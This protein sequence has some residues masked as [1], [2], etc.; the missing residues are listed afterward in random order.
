MPLQEDA[1]STPASEAAGIGDAASET[2][3]SSPEPLRAAQGRG[4]PPPVPT[5]QCL[6]PR[7]AHG[8]PYLPGCST[9]L[10]L[11]SNGT[12]VCSPYPCPKPVLSPVSQGTA[13]SQSVVCSP[14][15]SCPPSLL[16]PMSPHCS[17][18]K[19][20]LSPAS[21]GTA[22][23]PTVV[24]SPHPSCPPS[25][26]SP[27]SPHC[28]CPK[29]AL[30]PV[31][32]GTSASPTVCSPHPS[33][34]PSLLSPTNPHGSCPKPLRAPG[35]NASHDAVSPDAAVRPTDGSPHP[36]CP[37]PLRTSGDSPVVSPLGVVTSPMVDT[38]HPSFCWKA[39]EKKPESHTGG[40]SP[41]GQS[42]GGGSTAVRS[43]LATTSPVSQQAVAGQSPSR[44]SSASHHAETPR[45]LALAKQRST[46]WST[47]TNE[48]NDFTAIVFPRESKTPMAQRTR[49]IPPLSGGF[50]PSSPSPRTP[51]VAARKHRLH[52]NASFSSPHPLTP[53]G[54][55]NLPLPFGGDAD[56]QPLASPG[57]AASSEVKG[58]GH[59]GIQR[60]QTGLGSFVEEANGMLARLLQAGARRGAE[61]VRRMLGIAEFL[62]GIG[63]S[64]ELVGELVTGRCT[65][66]SEDLHDMRRC[67]EE[68]VGR[69]ARRLLLHLG[70][71]FRSFRVA[72]GVQNLSFLSLPGTPSPPPVS[73]RPRLPER[74]D[75]Y[76]SLSL[77]KHSTIT[78]PVP[79]DSP[80]CTAHSLNHVKQSR[81]GPQYAVPPPVDTR[82]N[83]SPR[84]QHSPH[85]PL[86]C[87]SAKLLS[88]IL[89]RR[90]NQTQETGILCR[91]CEI[92]V[93]SSRIEQHT[94]MCAERMT[95][96]MVMDHVACH[97]QRFVKE[98]PAYLSGDPRKKTILES[99]ASCCTALT[100]EQS[101]P[102]MCSIQ[103]QMKRLANE[104][105]TWHDRQ[106]SSLL[107]S[108]LEACS[109]VVNSY[110]VAKDAMDPGEFAESMAIRGSTH[111]GISDFNIKGV[112]ARGAFGRIFLVE[113]RSTRDLY[114]LKVMSKNEMFHRHMTQKLLNERNI[115]AFTDSSL[116]VKLHYSFASTKYLYFALEYHAGGDLFSLLE[117]HGS[118]SEPLAA[119]YA[120]EIFLALEFLHRMSIFHRD[121]KP[122]NI[123]LADSGHVKLTD[124]GLSD[125]GAG[126]VVDRIIAKADVAFD[127][128]LQRARAEQAG[129]TGWEGGDEKSA[130][131]CLPRASS[132][133]AKA[134]LGAER[135]RVSRC[136]G[137]PDYVAPEIVLGEESDGAAD[138]WSLGVML[139]E[140]VTGAPPFSG[141][142]PQ[143]T[144][145]NILRGKYDSPRVLDL[146][147]EVT[148]L[149]GSL[150]Q[151]QPESR[152]RDVKDHPFFA[153]VSWS[154]LLSDPAPYVPDLQRD[155][156][157]ERSA[158]FPTDDSDV[159]FVKEDLL[160]EIAADHRSRAETVASGDK[161][162]ACAE[163]RKHC[164]P[165]ADA[166]GVPGVRE[167][168]RQPNE[169]VCPLPPSHPR[170]PS[171]PPHP[172]PPFPTGVCLIPKDAIVPHPRFLSAL[173]CN[174]LPTSDSQRMRWPAH[175]FYF[176]PYF[177]HLLRL[178]SPSKPAHCFRTA[179]GCDDS[180]TPS[181]STPQLPALSSAAIP[182]SKPAHCSGQDSQRMR[183]PAHSF[184]FHPNFLHLLW[185]QSPLPNQCMFS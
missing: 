120:A 145:D 11:V 109:S 16:S 68:P 130:D 150:L 149:I 84:T 72:F 152:T 135:N 122:D 50:P 159:E 127:S 184:Y 60:L 123:L 25:L 29:S 81:M 8:S 13:A 52:V 138:L 155:N 183:W 99:I 34:P 163:P 75:S 89:P 92:P 157:Y 19:S 113:K 119:F 144:F 110:K 136:G 181:I 48:R 63:S 141:D 116:V 137:T 166:F 77:L 154:T 111:V 167:F 96:I 117:R 106:L 100:R 49:S 80:S 128:C 18:L 90:R 132:F 36:F 66:A 104:A 57:V 185:L 105:E 4:A 103:I 95:S 164:D 142:T 78:P 59:R 5:G 76:P 40:S 174:L 178:Q 20:V 139:Y 148:E 65:K 165:L 7:A 169:N 9:S 176:H 143:E 46:E 170:P 79:P 35:D 54:P 24:C 56:A 140:F 86:S 88:S 133:A 17:C 146:S 162:A 31:S 42:P 156:F 51:R 98:P 173:H 69:L 58:A 3:P 102:A 67:G 27:T 2:S 15:P 62:R 38:P 47:M 129:E 43:N 6:L 182:P 73:L 61:Q 55:T 44:G 21:H 147:E 30:S 23:S 82:A 172:P 53:T 168:L 151:F 32:Q 93:G 37:M 107:S 171:S 74:S 118:L 87:L 14:H 85:T 97:L 28:S 134:G 45:G 41:S 33:C 161:P 26:L 91:I 160:C 114:A 179:K 39:H 124:F 180:H 158:V 12:T 131:G 71:F 121:L 94:Q 70:V 22:A 101:S 1:G 153:S 10:S 126:F 115:M 177:P 112:I 64:G 83:I 175:S 108:S 125:V